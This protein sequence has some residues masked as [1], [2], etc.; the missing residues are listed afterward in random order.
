MKGRI[1]LLSSNEL[2]VTR[3]QALQVLERVESLELALAPTIFDANIEPAEKKEH[4]KALVMARATVQI[5]AEENKD[6]PW[7]IE[8]GESEE[9]VLFKAGVR[10][11]MVFTRAAEIVRSL[12]TT[13]T[14][15]NTELL[16]EMDRRRID[17]F[18]PDGEWKDLKQ[19][20]R[21]L[22][23][24]KDSSRDKDIL[25]MTGEI[26]DS[27]EAAGV[28]AKQIAQIIQAHASERGS[29][30]SVLAVMATAASKVLKDRTLS[31]EE[32]FEALKAI[33]ADALV[34]G[35]TR[36]ESKYHSRKVPRLPYYER[37]DEEGSLVT[38]LARTDDQRDLLLGRMRDAM[39]QSEFDLTSTLSPGTVV[40]YMVEEDWEGL[41]KVSVLT[42]PARRVV[43]GMMQAGNPPFDREHFLKYSSLTQRDVDQALGDLMHYGLVRLHSAIGSRRF[44]DLAVRDG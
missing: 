20:V 1:G 10:E 21:D 43:Y 17:L 41:L 35:V 39:I 30:T 28:D 4:M 7:H 8:E 24:G 26:G 38:F 29:G 13:L 19:I 22:H 23:M 34:M 37:Q 44:W 3:E 5:D 12:E 16:R 18:P 31:T 32:K 36:L 15:T 27:Y 33:A 25:R 14:I 40:K 42:D 9:K 6:S 2:T 11:Y